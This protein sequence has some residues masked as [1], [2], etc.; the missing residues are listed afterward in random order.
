MEIWVPNITKAIDRFN[1]QATFHSI[2]LSI[3]MDKEPRI[4][5]LPCKLPGKVQERFF[6]V[7]VA[8]SRDFIVLQILLSVECNL[9]CLDLPVLHVNLVSTKDNGYVLTDPIIVKRKSQGHCFS[10]RK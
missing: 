8:L 10:I 1:F 2:K 9:L 6:K 5:P 7:V 4:V 3:N